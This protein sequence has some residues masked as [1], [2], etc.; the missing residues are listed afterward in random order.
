MKGAFLTAEIRAYLKLEA[1]ISAAFNFFINGMLA[2]L[3][4]HRADAVP[5]NIVSIPLDLLATCLLMFILSAYFARAS[6]KRSKA[7]GILECDRKP[8]LRL[9]R[10]LERPLLYGLALGL[11]AGIA[12]SLTVAPAFALTGAASLPF[13]WYIALK[14]AFAAALGGAF[15]ALTLYAGMCKPGNTSACT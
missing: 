2:A 14:A 13:G 9:A 7:A 1:G 6:L 3:V 15:T 12:L 10:L 4:Y 11:P 8:F 5:T